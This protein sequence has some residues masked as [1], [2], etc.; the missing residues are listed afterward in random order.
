[1]TTN[2]NQA[3]Q[4]KMESKVRHIMA[5]TFGMFIP[6]LL[7]T[8]DFPFLGIWIAGVVF[9]I[10]AFKRQDSQ[11]AMFGMFVAIISAMLIMGSIELADIEKLNQAMPEYPI[12]NSY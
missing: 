10:Y 5:F 12:D 4:E 2:L 3:Y 8:W 7:S 11:A 6:V 1:M 9:C